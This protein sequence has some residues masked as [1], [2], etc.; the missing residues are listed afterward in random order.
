M[1]PFGL[2]LTTSNGGEYLAPAPQKSGL[3]ENLILYVFERVFLKIL[4]DSYVNTTFC[5]TYIGDDQRSF[6]SFW[7]EIFFG[8]EGVSN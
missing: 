2:S 8:E 7:E 4:Y 5:M 1:W 6:L 3:G